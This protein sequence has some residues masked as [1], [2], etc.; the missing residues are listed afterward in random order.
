MLSDRHTAFFVP[1]I[2][3]NNNKLFSCICRKTTKKN[4]KNKK[5][6][7]NCTKTV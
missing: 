1:E 2:I 3:P 6:K 7:L 5:L 4:K